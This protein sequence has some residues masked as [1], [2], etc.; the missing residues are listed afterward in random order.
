MSVYDEEYT[1]QFP[2][3]LQNAV[4]A[5]VALTHSLV[6][7]HGYDGSYWCEER[8]AIA[9]LAAWQAFLSYQPERNVPLEKFALRCA[10][11]A[12]VKE[13]KRL[14]QQWRCTVSIPVDDE[15]GEEIEFEDPNA[16]DEIEEQLLCNIIRE[17][18]NKLP[19]EQ[20]DV[21]ELYY[22]TGLSEREIAHQLGR[23]KSWVHR[24]VKKALQAL[25]AIV[26]QK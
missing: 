13:W 18:M 11:R 8:T 24:C 25:R 15:T 21:L 10:V 3:E 2:P 9:N 26:G 20:L 22:G 12:I 5:A 17:A 7:P 6:P 23:C 14:C 16:Q 19:R 1:N 4:R